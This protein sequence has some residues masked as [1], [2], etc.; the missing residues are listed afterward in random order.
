MAPPGEVEG[1]E[2]IPGVAGGTGVADS[3]GGVTIGTP[4]ASGTNPK[5]GRRSGRRGGGRGSR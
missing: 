1:A 4:S 2:G 5:G 3:G